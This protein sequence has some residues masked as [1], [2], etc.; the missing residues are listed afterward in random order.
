MSLE[1]PFGRYEVALIL[2]PGQVTGA[3]EKGKTGVGGEAPPSLIETT[4]L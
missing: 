3:D 4:L 1:R 2:G